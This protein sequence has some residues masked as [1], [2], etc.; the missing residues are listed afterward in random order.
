MNVETAHTENIRI[1]EWIAYSAYRYNEEIFKARTHKM[2]GAKL[3]DKYPEAGLSRVSTWEDG[4]VTS[5]NTFV[6]REE[7]RVIARTAGQLTDEG[8]RS[9][10][11][12]ASDDL[13]CT[14]VISAPAVSCEGL[15]AEAATYAEAWAKF[16]KARPKVR[17][18]EAD[19]SQHHGFITTAGRFTT[20]EEALSIARKA[21]QIVAESDFTRAGVLTDQDTLR[22]YDDVMHIRPPDIK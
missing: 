14:E 2:A 15:I 20:P 3:L 1:P 13:K 4:F 9:S 10:G 21:G 7:A 11:A 6:N 18:D 16:Q 5:E 22:P 8:K 19:K 17:I 12:L